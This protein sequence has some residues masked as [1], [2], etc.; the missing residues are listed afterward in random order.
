MLEDVRGQLNQT[1]MYNEA[2]M[3]R[4]ESRL[5]LKIDDAQ[6]NTDKYVF[7]IIINI[8]LNINLFD[9]LI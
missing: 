2:E 9:L 6:R 7:I 8:Y 4:L 5:L 1:K 3:V